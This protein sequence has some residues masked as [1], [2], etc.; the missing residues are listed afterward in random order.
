M[1]PAPILLLRFWGQHNPPRGLDVDQTAVRRRFVTKNTKSFFPLLE[2]FKEPKTLEQDRIPSSTSL[3]H[4]VTEAFWWTSC[5]GSLHKVWGTKHESIYIWKCDTVP[6]H[7]PKQT[8]VT[9]LQK[10]SGFSTFLI[11]KS[12]LEKAVDSAQTFRERARF[13]ASKAVTH[14]VHRI[15]ASC[16]QPEMLCCGHILKLLGGKRRWHIR[17]H[18]HVHI[19]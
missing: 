17:A 18:G 8:S 13:D 16:I 14:S 12:C 1:I 5:L 7:S 19:R 15:V 10:G 6:L 2:C 4:G 11:L 3:G 9:V